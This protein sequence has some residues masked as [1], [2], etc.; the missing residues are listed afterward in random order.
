MRLALTLPGAPLLWGNGQP[1][2]TR[3]TLTAVR[4]QRPRRSGAATAPVSTTDDSMD[5][6]S[7][8]APDPRPPE[9]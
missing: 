3:T 2:S 7:T 9:P 1:D 5:L 8:L 6:H 4:S